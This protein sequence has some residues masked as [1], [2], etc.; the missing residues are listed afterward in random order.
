MAQLLSGVTNT[1]QPHRP[2]QRNATDEQI[3]GYPEARPARGQGKRP[4]GPA[5]AGWPRV[6]CNLRRRQLG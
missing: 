2:E 4:T 6:A 3:M 5:V 1:D